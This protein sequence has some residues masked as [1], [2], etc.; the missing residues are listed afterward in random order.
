MTTHLE[1]SLL[2]K[3][4]VLNELL[5]EARC[6]EPV[7][8]AWRS[9]FAG[10]VLS[11]EQERLHAL[12][13]LSHLTYFG[14]REVREL[15]KCMYRDFVRAPILREIRSKNPGFRTVNDYAAPLQAELLGTRFLGM[16]NPAESGT[17]LLYYFRQEAELS[18][19]L[20]V[21]E[22]QLFTGD[23]LNPT[24][25]LRD[26][27]LHRI[28]FIDD[29]CGSGQQSVEYSKT[30]LPQIK[31]VALRTGQAVELVYL[32]LFG[33]TAGMQN[34][35]TNSAFDRVECAGE[36]DLSFLT[37]SANSR[38]FAT[39]P[40]EVDIVESKAIAQHYGAKIEPLQPLGYGNGEL[41]MAFHHNIPDNTL[42]II[43][44]EGGALPWKA[45]LKRAHKIY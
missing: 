1:E 36:M 45:L 27:N 19:K 6:E 17:H 14:L 12:F 42:P 29:I 32:V 10:E 8:D 44:S 4:K 9:N 40:S 33:T 39:A 22:H 31:S 5:W 7:I 24:T 25:T 38:V 23:I 41:L 43:W 16:G 35:R 26:P 13:L 28:V 18:K 11:E 21:H 2:R 20:F 30:I 15:L 37:Y 3:I 34:A